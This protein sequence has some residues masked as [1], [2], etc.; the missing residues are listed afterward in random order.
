MGQGNSEPGSTLLLDT[1]TWDLCVDAAGNIA[2]A[3]APYSAAQ[4]AASAVR[5]FL[6]EVYYQT[7]TGLP[8][9]EEV[10]GHHPPLS[11][12][13]SQIVSAALTVPGVLSAVCFI[14]S[15]SGRTVT[16]QLQV[17]DTSGTQ[18]TVAF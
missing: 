7:N 17:R 12:L 9:F 6:G 5:T 3:S 16:G 13:K 11:L 4:D 10:L 8:Y 2:C 1:L 15:V 18:T 14:S